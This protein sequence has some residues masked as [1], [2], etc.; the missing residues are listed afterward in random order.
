MPNLLRSIGPEIMWAGVLISV[1]SNVTRTGWSDPVVIAEIIGLVLVLGWIIKERLKE[2]K[3]ELL[4]S[5]L[6]VTGT[7]GVVAIQNSSWTR[8]AVLL[9]MGMYIF[10]KRSRQDAL[11]SD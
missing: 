6:Y 8:L 11:V 4:Y 2:Q 5:L 10:A 1:S 3:R 7:V 9:I